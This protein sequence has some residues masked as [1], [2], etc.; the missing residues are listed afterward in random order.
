MKKTSVNVFIVILLIALMATCLFACGKNE[1]ETPEDP[2]RETPA[3]PENPSNPAQ[4]SDPVQP[5]VTMTESY[6]KGR[7][8]FKAVTGIELPALEN[9]TVEEFPYEEG[10]KSYE[11]DITENVTRGTFDTIVAFLDAALASWTKEGPT[12]AGDYTDIWYRNNTGSIGITWDS[13]NVA[14]YVHAIMG[15]NQP[16]QPQ[17]PAPTMTDSYV[18]ARS[19]FQAATG[20]LLPELTSVNGYYMSA[21]KEIDVG[22]STTGTG[23]TADTLAKVNAAL[24]RQINVDPTTNNGIT[25]WTYTKIKEDVTYDCTVRSMFQTEGTGGLVVVSYSEQAQA[26]ET[27]MTASYQNGRNRF[28]DISG[29]WLPE[30]ENIELDADSSFDTQK[31]EA[32]L[33]VPSNADTFTSIV[34]AVKSALESEPLSNN[35]N[36]WEEVGWMA[37]WEWD[38]EAGGRMHKVTIQL[39]NNTYTHKI[40]AGYWFRDY[41]TLTLTAGEG[42]T[43]TLEIAGRGQDGNT[44]HVVY[45]TAS[46]LTATPSVGYEFVGFY[47]RNAKVSEDNPYRYMIVKDVTIEA[48]F[49]EIPSNMDEG[50]KTARSALYDMSGIVLPEL[51]NVTT[52]HVTIEPDE[53]ELRDSF[54]CEFVF[55]T[56]AEASEAYASFRTVITAVEGNQEETSNNEYGAMDI[57]SPLFSDVIVPYRHDV[58]M[59]IQADATSLFLMWRKQPIV[60]YS[61]AT[62]GNGTAY[63]SYTGSDY[64]EHRVE[65]Y[66]E[67]ADAFHGK[68][69]A[70]AA[71]GNEFVGWYV[72]G[73]LVSENATYNFSSNQTVDFT[74]ITFV[75]KFEELPAPTMTESYASARTSFQ[76]ISGIVLP[77]LADVTGLF[78]QISPTTWMVDIGSA[79]ENVYASVKTA[80]GQQTGV[81]SY[82]N[83][84]NM[85]T[86]DFSRTVDGTTYVCQ[87]RSVFDDGI[88]MFMYEQNAVTASYIEGRALYYD[89]T[90]LLLPL[91]AGVEAETSPY[92]PGVSTGLEVDICEGATKDMSDTI[93]TFFDG[94]DG[95][96][97]EEL[98]GI[99]QF[100]TKDGKMIGFTWDEDNGGLYIHYESNWE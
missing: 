3:N 38:Y 57:W 62:E 31:K 90:G 4:P 72:D 41:Y 94:L 71:Q 26:P 87:V 53:E 65:R 81:T 44:A 25:T 47:E 70:E 28:H 34:S 68:V 78:E 9:I 84:N 20:L 21:E 37:F 24:A 64:E 96:T 80:F 100:Y 14:V 7:A 91:L 18:S 88:V 61:V 54:Q 33:I 52:N 43:A 13:H 1:L 8:E 51:E 97:K 2:G 67:I 49:Q 42:G 16:E 10:A 58:M 30:L 35:D 93:E 85:D 95:W 46:E 59:D 48:R 66:W 22:G 73:V 89:L 76:T 83:A 27:N 82:V 12:T 50:Y 32:Q 79:N 69:V 5:V 77:E 55:A 45:N 29:I 98:Q 17:E 36:H 40:T 19:A 63:V 39:E 60:F 75:A 6:A 74:E 56:A 99:N 15:G 11:L 86:W 92:T 23:A